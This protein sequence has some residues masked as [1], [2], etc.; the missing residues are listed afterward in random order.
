M[1]IIKKIPL[2][3]SGV[4]LGVAGLGNLLQSY[5]TG[6]RVAC[7]II[8]GVLLIL[9]LLKIFLFPSMVKEDM[10]NPIMASVVGTFPMAVMILSVYI[11]PFIG[12][13]AFYIWLLAIILHGVLIL[14]F[15]YQ[16]VLK[17]KIDMVFASYY[18]V[19]VGI[20]VASMT[21]PTYE[22][23]SLG[24][25]L[26]WFGF[27]LFVLLLILVSY[28]YITVPKVPEPARP[29]ICIYAAPM[30]LCINGYVQ[31]VMP[32]S[33][34]FLLG[35]YIVASILYLF[36]LIQGIRCLRLSFYPSYASFTFPFVISALA[37]KQVMACM[38][39]LGSPIPWLYYAVVL[40][41]IIATIFVIYTLIRY[42]GF[43]VLSPLEN[44][45]K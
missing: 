25:V 2:P 42:I 11:K 43:F 37:S 44:A 17:L 34:P 20:V 45:K 29:L 15:T 19:Y 12:Q 38:Q 26:F 21:A 5:S 32:K 3:L 31:S 40:E 41:T 28:R 30:S 13:V 24:S 7:G 23:A 6:S 33:I 14:Y 10:K 22:M 36:G 39:T 8:A 1:N 18:I 9:L 16:F 4:M 35:M 27:I